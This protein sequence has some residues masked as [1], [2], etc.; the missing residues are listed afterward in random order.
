M[1]GASSPG[2]QSITNE[3]KSCSF[4]LSTTSSRYSNSV[5]WLLSLVASLNSISALRRKSTASPCQYSSYPPVPSNRYQ[6]SVARC[7]T[8][9]HHNPHHH[10]IPHS[11]PPAHLPATALPLPIRLLM[12]CIEPALQLVAVSLCP[13]HLVPQ[14]DRFQLERAHLIT[15]DEVLLPQSSSIAN[16]GTESHASPASPWLRGALPGL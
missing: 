15:Y 16:R 4:T 5:S 14:S 11:T 13:P 9:S 6:Y 2:Q 10:I 3:A 12:S 7:H 1:R 8:S